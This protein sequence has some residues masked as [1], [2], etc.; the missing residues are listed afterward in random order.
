[1]NIGPIYAEPPADESLR[2]RPAGDPRP[3]RL[4]TTDDPDKTLGEGEMFRFATL[5]EAANA[6]AKAD[7]SA[8]KTIIYDDGLEARALDA[9]EAQ[10]VRDVCALLGFDVI[11]LGD[12]AVEVDR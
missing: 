2:W 6:F 3:W 12:E 4:I 8:G 11:N 10:F 1:V 5:I 7:G 9:R